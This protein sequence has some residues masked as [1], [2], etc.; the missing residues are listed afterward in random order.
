VD[1]VAR[2]ELTTKQKLFCERYIVDFN[3]TRAYLDVFDTESE[4]VAGINASK[5]LKREDIRLY[6]QELI[7]EKVSD[8]LTPDRILF[9]LMDLAFNHDGSVPHGVKLQALST[10]AK[11][12][13]MEVTK[14]QLEQVIFEGENE[15]MD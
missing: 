9:E 4:K 12:M 6:I 5:L 7:R 10:L 15:M 13:G 8:D 2:K 14:I 11:L 1:N 3:G